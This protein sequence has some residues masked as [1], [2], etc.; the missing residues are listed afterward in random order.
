M[1]ESALAAQFADLLGLVEAQRA[2]GE[3]ATATFRLAGRLLE[4]TAPPDILPAVAEPLGHLAVDGG[5]A[6][7][8]WH[9]LRRDAEFAQRVPPRFTWER[10]RYTDGRYD[11]RVDHGHGGIAAEDRRTSVSV[12]VAADVDEDVWRRPESSRPYLERLLA[13]RGLVSVHGGTIGTRTHGILVTA[14]GGRGKS[15]LVAGAVRAGWHTTGD[16]FLCLEHGA[17][18]PLLHSMYRTVKVA[19]DS[20]A[21]RDRMA[22]GLL[23]DGPDGKYL[24]LLDADRPGC[25]VPSHVPVALV[26]PRRGDRVSLGPIDHREA[27]AALVPSSAAMATDRASAVRSLSALADGLPCFSLTL[28]RDPEAELDALAGLLPEATVVGAGPIAKGGGA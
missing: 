23:S 22:A 7:L 8:T 5:E 11:F 26:V 21:W 1:T 4:I 17:S 16:D 14:P 6:E 2:S 24:T 25:L 13:A 15:S 28:A 9:L 3:R 10:Q 18:G 20:P 27:V 12:L 19:P